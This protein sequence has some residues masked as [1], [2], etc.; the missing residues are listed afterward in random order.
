MSGKLGAMAAMGLALLAAPAAAATPDIRTSAANA[1][2]ACV[3]PDRL[4]AYLKATNG[5]LDPSFGDIATYYKQ[6]GEELRVRWDYAFFQMLL[7]T[8]YLKYTG[9]DRPKQN[10]FAGIGTTGG[11][12]RGN[13]FPDVSTGVRVHIEHL[14]AYSG[15]RL[16]NPTGKRTRENQDD[17]IAVTRKQSR[18]MTFGDLQMRWAID[19]GYARKIEAVAGRFAAA[20]CHG[21]AEEVVA[22]KTAPAQPRLGPPQP[23][24]VYARENDRGVPAPVALYTGRL[25]A[26]G[27]VEE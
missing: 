26:A 11:G 8:N 10:N 6:H 18:P 2:P 1:V 7:E 5:R 3:S 27:R 19:R 4:M 13:A 25:S 24:L 23:I 16:A 9:A 21:P 14:V 17:I 22:A 12:V 15:E 20:H